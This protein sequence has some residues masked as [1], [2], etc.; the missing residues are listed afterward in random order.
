M[1]INKASILKYGI[2]ILIGFTIRFYYA[3]TIPLTNDEGSYLYD[4]YLLSRGLWPFAFSFSRAPA[5]M[6]IVAFVTKIFGNGIFIGR[7]I[8]IFAGLLCSKV[9]Y[10][11]GKA[12]INEKVGYY[13]FLSYLLI[14]VVSVHN[15]RIHTQTLETL[16]VMLGIWFLILSLDEL[17]KV[18]SANS[19]TLRVSAD[20]TQRVFPSRISKLIFS[21]TFFGLAVLTRETSAIFPAIFIVYYLITNI[22][23]VKEGIVSYLLPPLAI[24]IASLLVWGGAWSVIGRNVGFDK[25]FGIFRALTTMHDTGEIWSLGFTLKKKVEVVSAWLNENFIFYLLGLVFIYFILRFFLNI[26]KKYSDF[27]LYTSY[28]LLS[29]L[30][31]PGFLDF[32]HPELSTVLRYIVTGAFLILFGWLMNSM[33]KIP[34][35]K[36]DNL[37]LFLIVC[38]SSVVFYG[39]YYRRL[40]PGY[41]SEFMP[42]FALFSGLALSSIEIKKGREKLILSVVTLFLLFYNFIS[43]QNVP[44]SGTFY[45]KPINEVVSW[46]DVNSGEDDEI[47]TSA[48]IF[49]YL[50]NRELSLNISR[51]VIF[52]YPHLAEDIKYT[53]F[54]R[55]SEILRYLKDNKVKFVVVE[56]SMRDSF[57]NYHDEIRDYVFDNY[58]TAEIFENRGNPIEVHKLN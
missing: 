9:I 19:S 26:N 41:F 35:V 32:K 1:R 49:P 17:Y 34:K 11:I 13:S 16:F 30:L 37:I 12:L 39:L 45:L 15:A 10:K 7:L 31:L 33:R 57:F 23:R 56:K 53:L 14:P 21:G 51:P 58:H 42:G 47:F 38:L 29:A 20:L 4:G 46:F 50:A 3:Q 25:V 24:G 22:K 48:V 40:Q 27:A 36:Q 8:S 44:H 52:G 54:P 6:V 43:I 5:L 2:P 18:K 28:F 55:D